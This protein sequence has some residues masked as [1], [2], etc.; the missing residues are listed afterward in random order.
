ME[1]GGGRGT[2]IGANTSVID[3]RENRV[4]LNADF[5]PTVSLHRDIE[6]NYF[7]EVRTKLKVAKVE[8][9]SCGVDF[10]IAV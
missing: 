9:R 2:K 1:G 6:S 7:I 4:A 3:K 8:Q 10:S 5:E